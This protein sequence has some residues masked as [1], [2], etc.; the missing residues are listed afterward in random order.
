MDVD[1][2][3]QE[4]FFTKVDSQLQSINKFFGKEEIDL[5][6]ALSELEE[7][8]GWREFSQRFVKQG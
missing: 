6:F 3:L 7:K 2:E 1:K 8:V 4:E 5:Q